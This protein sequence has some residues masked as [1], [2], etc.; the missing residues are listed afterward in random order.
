MIILSFV[1]SK[2]I[3]NLFS[4]KLTQPDIRFWSPKIGR[5]KKKIL[6]SDCSIIWMQSTSKFETLIY[7]GIVH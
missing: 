6:R 1:R 3:W 2:K 4:S 5:T 7:E